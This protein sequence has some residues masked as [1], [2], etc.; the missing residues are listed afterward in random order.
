MSQHILILVLTLMMKAA[1]FWDAIIVFSQT[2]WRDGDNKAEQ[3]N[4]ENLRRFKLE[5]FHCSKMYYI[6]YTYTKINGIG[7]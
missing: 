2:H 5:N 1:K 6:V 3:N 4:I 7:H